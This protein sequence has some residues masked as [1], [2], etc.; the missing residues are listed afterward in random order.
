MCSVQSASLRGAMCSVLHN[1]KPLSGVLYGNKVHWE[2]L[3]TGC[4]PRSNDSRQVAFFDD[5]PLFHLFS[6]D[7]PSV[8]KVVEH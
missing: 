7:E 6:C 4:P 5:Q 2:R 3:A 1:T 8:D